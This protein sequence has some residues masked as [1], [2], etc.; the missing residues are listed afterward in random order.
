MSMPMSAT[1]GSPLLELSGV[2]AGYGPIAVLHGID[3]TVAAGEIV[4]VLGANGA[5]KTTL[6]RAISGVVPVRHGAIRFGERSILGMDGARIVGEGLSHVPEGRE[7]FA[8]LTVRENLMMGAYR[9]SDRGAIAD[10]VEQAYDYFPVL[11][12]R[13]H[14]AAGLLSGGQQQMLAIARGMMARPRLMLLD[15]PSLGLSPLLTREIWDILVRLNRERGTALLLVEQ[16]VKLALR[17]A[18][19]AYVMELGRVTMTGAADE[20]A[21]RPEIRAAYLGRAGQP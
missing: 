14:Q 15:E 12:E 16:N 13:L 19:R 11:R 1:G 21:D 7:I 3:M 2:A 17:I 6:L 10:D 20:I 9:R 4:A 8:G 18:R 5:G